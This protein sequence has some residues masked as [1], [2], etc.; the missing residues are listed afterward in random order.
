[1]WY[2]GKYLDSDVNV[3]IFFLSF[4]K[5]KTGDAKA[6]ATCRIRIKP[7][8]DSLVGRIIKVVIM[9]RNIKQELLFMDYGLNATT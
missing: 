1:M 8:Y 5:K 2:V 7:D 3:S 6:V 9:S 4:R